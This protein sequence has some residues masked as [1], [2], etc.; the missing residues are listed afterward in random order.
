VSL[1]WRATWVGVVVL[2]L[3]YLALA[4]FVSADTR[5]KDWWLPDTVMR[6]G[7]DLQGGIHW[8][9]GV[10]LDTAIEHELDFQAGQIK[11]A[12][13]ERGIAV[14]SV[15]RDGQALVVDSSDPETVRQAMTEWK[16]L[17]LAPGQPPGTS[18]P[19]RYVLT[20]AW[21][22]EVRENGM[23]QVLEVM[24]RRI[25]DPQTG[26]PESVV[27][28]Q[29]SDRILVQIPGGEIERGQ[30][31][32]LLDQTGFLEF[33]IVID[34]D[35]NEE[36]LRARY[37]DGLPEGTTIDFQRDKLT[38]RVQFAY[39]VPKKPDI[40]GDYLKH[41]AV[42]FDQRGRPVVNFTWKPAGAEIFGE[43]TAKNIG[44]Q[45]AIIVDKDVYSAP[46]IRSRIQTRGQIEGQFTSDEASELAVILRAGALSVP[47]E[48]EEE[49]T[50][51]PALGAD[52]IRRGLD[53]SVIGLLAVVAF[54]GIY[55]RLSGVYASIALLANLIMIIGLMSMFG[56]TLTM[57]GI[58]GLVLTVGMAIDANVI[59]FERIRE[60][61]RAGKLPRGAIRTGF[62]K[63]TWTILDANITTLITA[64]VLYEFGTGPIKGFA[65]TLSIGILT[66]VFTA[67]VVTR[68]LFQLWPGD[69]PVEAVSI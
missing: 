50:V 24:R 43:L 27:T 62:E 17:Q 32:T 51:G 5:L 35:R 16:Q 59:I 23:R 29:G 19:L 1:R 40:T 57:P 12:L 58:A 69:R 4:N 7:L 52:S 64:V 22:R 46:T 63:A 14:D 33:K 25:E 53:A 11:D 54:A 37:P 13:D 55:Y 34:Q 65:V 3:G 20:D 66:S 10:K 6:L 18:G 45:L 2:G 31:R 38:G 30:A 26:I 15:T 42:G 9:L 36:L 67:L 49:R 56:A 39:L 68:L 48:I 44:K 28:R 61:L 47:V 60:E 8:V 21:Q 41:A